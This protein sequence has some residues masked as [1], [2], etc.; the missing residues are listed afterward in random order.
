MAGNT[1]EDTVV[2]VLTYTLYLG[3]LGIVVGALLW[4]GVEPLPS[5]QRRWGTVPTLGAGV[6]FLVLSR[7]LYDGLRAR[8]EKLSG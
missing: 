1:L 7:M 6:S 3:W 8:S 2:E 4:L 5:L